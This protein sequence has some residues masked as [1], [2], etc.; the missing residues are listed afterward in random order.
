MPSL[1]AASA[2]SEPS[3]SLS[4]QLLLQSL[5][6]AQQKEP[7]KPSPEVESSRSIYSTIQALAQ[8]GDT[9]GR[10]SSAKQGAGQDP[11]VREGS[12]GAGGMGREVSPGLWVGGSEP[13]AQLVVPGK[14]SAPTKASVPLPLQPD[15]GKMGTSM[16]RCQQQQD[17]S[18]YAV[19]GQAE[20]LAQP[21]A[22]LLAQP[23]HSSTA[24]MSLL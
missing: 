12:P 8:V 21:L 14:D 2:S 9:H 16:P 15:E 4:P 5:S 10:V 7:Q 18:L 19:V 23:Q 13:S 3:P 6:C 20:P 17:K 1:A 11:R 22:Q 24:A